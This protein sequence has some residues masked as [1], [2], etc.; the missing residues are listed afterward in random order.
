MIIVKRTIFYE[1]FTSVMVLM[2]QLISFLGRIL[3]I[4]IINNMVR[5]LMFKKYEVVR[6]SKDFGPFEEIFQM[7]EANL[8]TY[9]LF[10]AW[11]GTREVVGQL[12][13]ISA[14]N[15]AAIKARFDAEAKEYASQRILVYKDEAVGEIM[16]EVMEH[17]FHL[18]FKGIEISYFTPGTSVESFVASGIA[19]YREAE[20]KK[21]EAEA[22]ERR[23]YAKECGRTAR[24][25]GINFVNVLR[26]GYEDESK[27]VAFKKAMERAQQIVEASDADLQNRLYHEIVECGRYR[28]T[29]ALASLGVVV[30]ADV[31]YMRFDE[32]FA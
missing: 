3:T 22:L 26:L 9:W 31:N 28:K 20:A 23:K 30:D 12:K 14:E 5:R 19:E 18:S 4:K 24:R 8:T 15:Y 27:L 10:G 29:A 25:L 2:F 11:G 7:R 16:T 32:L 1:V 6:L 13:E 21:H 17:M